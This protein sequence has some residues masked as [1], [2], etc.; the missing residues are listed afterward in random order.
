MIYFYLFVPRK[1]FLSK[2]PPLIK[3]C[4]CTRNKKGKSCFAKIVCRGSFA[5]LNVCHPPP[6]ILSPIPPYL[7]SLA[8]QDFDDAQCRLDSNC[9]LN[10]SCRVVKRFCFQMNIFVVLF[11]KT[12]FILLYILFFMGL[13]FKGNLF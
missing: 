10:P 1:S 9:G 6:T 4:N 8:W 2:T 13:I 11:A 5:L 3:E 7:P 12:N